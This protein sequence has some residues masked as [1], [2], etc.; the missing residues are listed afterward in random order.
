MDDGDHRQ[1]AGGARRGQEASLN[2]GAVAG[3]GQAATTAAPSGRRW[4]G[5]GRARRRCGRLDLRAVTKLWC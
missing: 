3:P 1:F 4:R 2:A 5:S